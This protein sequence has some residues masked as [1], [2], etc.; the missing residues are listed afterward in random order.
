MQ[1]IFD[2]LTK[3]KYLDEPIRNHILRLINDPFKKYQGAPNLSVV[4]F[5]TLLVEKYPES[6]SIDSWEVSICRTR[7]AKQNVSALKLLQIISVFDKYRVGLNDV[8]LLVKFARGDRR[9]LEFAKIL[10]KHYNDCGVYG[11]RQ[12]I[13]RYET[14]RSCPD[15]ISFLK[16]LYKKC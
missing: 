15:A 10:S 7:Q 4:Q 2:V 9:Q 1:E 5:S 13:Y 6:S 14:G 11:Y 12:R 16:I 8:A 3:Y